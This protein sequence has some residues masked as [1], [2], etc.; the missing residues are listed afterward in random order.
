MI[1]DFEEEKKI[2]L[3]WKKTEGLVSER[4]RAVMEP[5][6]SKLCFSGGA[7]FGQILNCV[8]YFQWSWGFSVTSLSSLP[9]LCYPQ[10][11]STLH[12]KKQP[13]LCYREVFFF[14]DCRWSLTPKLSSHTSLSQEH[15][16][17]F[18]TPPKLSLVILP[19]AFVNDKELSW[20][21]STKQ[22]KIESWMVCGRKYIKLQNWVYH[23]YFD[24][25][26]HFFKYSKT[27]HK[28][29]YLQKKS[30]C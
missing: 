10:Q 13:F 3:V 16:T 19:T 21:H 11:I 6:P 24:L 30:F 14:F 26:S 23:T 5:T 2:N 29:Y 18:Q 22:D 7:R 15:R 1:W 12:L 28:D 4:G 17:P 9:S 25:L 8:L 27:S 20:A